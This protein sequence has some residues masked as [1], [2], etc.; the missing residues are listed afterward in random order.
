MSNT[1]LIEVRKS[2]SL[3]YTTRTFSW[4]RHT[5]VSLSAAISPQ[6]IPPEI[7]SQAISWLPL[8]HQKTMLSVSRFFHDIALPFVFSSVRLYVLGG[9]E[10]FDML[11][12]HQ[13]DFALETE[14]VLMRRSWEIQH[15]ILDDPHFALLVKDMTVVVFT[16][17]QAIF[18]IRECVR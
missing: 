7:W 3:N 17:S 4:E 12:T 8:A 15:R 14:H 2:L 11:E 1:E 13:A 5:M 6:H 18:E 16:E 9:S 10:T